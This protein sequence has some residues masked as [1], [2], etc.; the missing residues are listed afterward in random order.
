MNYLLLPPI[1]KVMV[2]GIMFYA[3]AAANE[4]WIRPGVA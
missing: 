4:G 2:A 3:I 1:P